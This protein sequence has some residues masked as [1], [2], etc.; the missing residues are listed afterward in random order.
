MAT[1]SRA[2]SKCYQLTRA[3]IRAVRGVRTAVG[4]R[5]LVPV[6]I[7]R[8]STALLFD[9]LKS[10][11]SVESRHGDPAQN[12]PRAEQLLAV[13]RSPSH[14]AATIMATMGVRLL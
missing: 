8:V 6:V 4:R 7:V 11:G 1:G 9:S 14:T 3:P 5:K 2:N 13:M 12:Q 10:H